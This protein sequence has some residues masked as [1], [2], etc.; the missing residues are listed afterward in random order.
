M[1]RLKF[2]IDFDSTISADPEAFQ[3]I[4]R[5]LVA[6]CGHEVRIV[7]WRKPHVREDVDNFIKGYKLDQYGVEAIFCNGEAKKLHYQA[8]IWI[9]DHPCTID[10]GLTREPHFGEYPEDE[11]LKLAD[12]R[13][14]GQQYKDNFTVNHRALYKS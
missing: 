14:V 12:S 5:Y 10:F 8:D 6:A 13:P 4:I 1:K 11:E 2:G 7:T 3:D 9:D